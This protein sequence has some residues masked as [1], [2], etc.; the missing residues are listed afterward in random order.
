[1]T[2]EE[3]T[4]LE[5]TEDPKPS[6]LATQSERFLV[7]IE[8][9]F[10]AQIGAQIEFTDYQKTLAQHMFLKITAALE[11]AEKR[12]GNKNKLAYEWGNVNMPKLA[13]DAVHRVNLGLDALIDNHISPIPYKNTRLDKYDIDLRVGYAGKDLCRREL[14]V[15][16]PVDV[17]YHLVHATDKFKPIMKSSM[18]DI[19]G[20]NFEVV[21]PFAR[22]EVVGGF[23]YIVYENQAMNKLV[24]VDMAA[25][26]KAQDSA[27][28]DDFWGKHPLEM[29]YKTIVHRTA[30]KIPLDPKKTNIS[31]Y[32]YV[33][34]QSGEA[35]EAEVAGEIEAGAN[36]TLI[37]V[38]PDAPTT[39]S[40]GAPVPSAADLK[41]E[42]GK[43]TELATGTT[44][45]PTY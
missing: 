32:E 31:S 11:A 21:N 7:G 38:T 28:G 45:G 10:A 20:Y 39:D 44:D 5:K 24:F 12:R 8:T 17:I 25:F 2:D 34:A 18:N 33:E 22:G 9:Q 14:A 42:D 29:M 41:A 16:K 37:D 3:K 6:E 19:E 13:L 27:A 43:Q 15:V 1:M 26:K 35:T 36:K 30:S 40:D 4:E 23:G